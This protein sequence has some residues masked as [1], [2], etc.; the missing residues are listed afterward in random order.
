MNTLYQT[1]P[2]EGVHGLFLCKSPSI[3]NVVTVIN[4]TKKPRMIAW[5][6]WRIVPYAQES[7][8]DLLTYGNVSLEPNGS[9]EIDLTPYGDNQVERVI[10]SEVDLLEGTGIC[11][12]EVLSD[13]KNIPISKM[14]RLG[15]RFYPYE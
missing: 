14:H 8:N 12:Y 15:T 13:E 10:W 11:H 7:E 4:D 6:V 3:P 2:L 5:Q 9:K 1:I